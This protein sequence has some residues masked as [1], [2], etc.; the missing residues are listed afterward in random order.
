MKIKSQSPYGDKN[1]L[2]LYLVHDPKA[3]TSADEP[4]RQF[5]KNHTASWKLIDL[6]LIFVDNA[7]K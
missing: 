4:M 2:D 3:V 7:K 1:F 5:F 6:L